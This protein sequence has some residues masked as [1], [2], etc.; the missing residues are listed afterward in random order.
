MT[1]VFPE[2]DTF[3][4][5]MNCIWILCALFALNK[6]NTEVAISRYGLISYKLYDKH[7]HKHN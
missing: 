4:T 1:T 2:L 5:S 3:D 6:K 7:K